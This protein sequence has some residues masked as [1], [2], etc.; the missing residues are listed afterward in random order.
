MTYDEQQLK[1]MQEEMLIQV[2]EMDQPIGLISKKEGHLMSNINRNEA[3]HRAFSVFLFN[4][5]NQLL[6]QKRA[7]EKITFPGY[8]TNTW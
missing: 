6:L 4:E 7:C 2:N 3:L 1:F 8:W 5:D